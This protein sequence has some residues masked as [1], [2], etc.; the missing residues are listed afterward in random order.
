[1]GREFEMDGAVFAA[2][3]AMGAAIQGSM[4]RGAERRAQAAHCVD[5]AAMSA[6]VATLRVQLA[7][8]RREV[9]AYEE[10]V[11]DLGAAVMSMGQSLRKLGRPDLVRAA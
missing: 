2:Q 9:D 1:M 8:A 11:L 3:V 10:E 6:Q 4:E 5:V 7:A